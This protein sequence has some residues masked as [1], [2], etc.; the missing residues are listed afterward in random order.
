MINRRQHP[1]S[2]RPITTHLHASES[3]ASIRSASACIF[4]DNLPYNQRATAFTNITNR[5][6]QLKINKQHFWK[7]S[8]P[9][10]ENQL[11]NQSTKLTEPPEESP[12]SMDDIKTG[13]GKTTGSSM[14]STK[15]SRSKFIRFKYPEQ[16]HQRSLPH[17]STLEHV[18]PNCLRKFPNYT[19][20][21]M[22]QSCT[23]EPWGSVTYLK[24]HSVKS[25]TLR[26]PK[27]EGNE[28]CHGPP[29]FSGPREQNNEA[30]S[31]KSI[32]PT[33]CDAKEYE[34][35]GQRNYVYEEPPKQNY[36]V[37]LYEEDIEE[38]AKN[39]RLAIA[40]N[41]KRDTDDECDKSSR[42]SVIS[43]FDELQKHELLNKTDDLESSDEGTSIIDETVTRP[44]RA[45]SIHRYSSDASECESDYV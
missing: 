17:Q 15:K 42:S 10:K 45:S 40:R 16:F 31:Q 27:D 22:R 41:K 34:R 5:F 23:H 14:V 12:T 37:E 21:P 25:S 3:Q 2:G 4:T 29:A 28:R 43:I 24:K 36:T 38:D 9:N 11:F 39:N 30:E 26:H 7:Q 1:I 6:Q 44:T 13:I 33:H 18:I 20:L 8:H 19:L 35:N 32:Y